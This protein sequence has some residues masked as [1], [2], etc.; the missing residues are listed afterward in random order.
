MSK[1]APLAGNAD[2]CVLQPIALKVETVFAYKA[3]ITLPIDTCYR[4]AMHIR[5]HEGMSQK[6]EQ[7]LTHMSRIL[8]VHALLQCEDLL[9]LLCQVFLHGLPL[10]IMPAHHFTYFIQCMQSSDAIK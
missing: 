10:P 5:S 2:G 9:A 8:L 3:H 6:Q 7:Q 4:P 1:F